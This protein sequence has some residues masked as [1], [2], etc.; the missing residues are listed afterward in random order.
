MSSLAAKYKEYNRLR[1]AISSEVAAG[2]PSKPRRKRKLEDNVTL[3]P[4]KRLKSPSATSIKSQDRKAEEELAPADLATPIV[5][6]T[7]MGPTP[8]RD[9]KILGIFDLLPDET[10]GKIRAIFGS[11][12]TNV[13]RTPSKPDGELKDSVLVEE[14]ARGSRTPASTGK[15]FLLDSFVTPR[16][17]KLGE[18]RTPSSSRKLF[19]TPA[20]LRRDTF[21]L[22]TVAEEPQSPE[23]ARPWQ[24]RTFGRSLSGMI[25][26]LRKQEDEQGDDEWDAIREMED[27]EASFKLS[28]PKLIVEDI[29]RAVVLD[30]EGFV[31]SEVEETEE[32]AE[33]QLDRN[34][35]P[36]KAWKK[37]GLKRQTRRVISKCIPI[38]YCNDQ[39]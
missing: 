3:T 4:P 15:R 36:R 20:F 28:T 35:Q 7:M 26:E 12:H 5:K 30:A 1:K 19:G 29:Q 23:I 22:S 24:R 6:K 14:R 8:Q 13:M 37:K 10:P 17:H 25:K 34:G 38:V 31:P 16:K 9:G 21:A 27:A 18:E 2:T 11:I 33:P 39:C 32:E